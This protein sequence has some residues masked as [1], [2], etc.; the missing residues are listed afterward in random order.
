MKRVHGEI[1]WIS[2][3]LVAAL[4]SIA[5][6]AIIAADWAEGL[7]VIW[8]VALGGL[9]A[10][11]VLALS[12]FPPWLAHGFSTVYGLGWGAYWLSQ[13]VTTGETFRERLI[14]IDHRLGVWLWQVTHNEVGRDSLIFVLLLCGLAWWLAYL[15]V[16]YSQRFNRIW[17]VVLPSGLVMFINVYYA[18][19]TLNVYLG[20]YLLAA[21]LLV[22]RSYILSQEQDWRQNLV[23]YTTDIRFDLLRAG[24]TLALV[25]ILAG[26]VVPAAASSDTVAQAWHRIEGP[27]R[28]VEDTWS[29]IFA[30]LRSRG[31]VYAD[32]FGRF[33][34]LQG[35]RFLT[36]SPVMDV[37]SS[38][39]AYWR[40][41]AFNRYTGSGWMATST[42]ALSL[43]AYDRVYR[44]DAYVSREQAPDIASAPGQTVQYAVYLRHPV[45][46]TVVIFRPATS[47]VFAAPEP[48]RFS[49]PVRTEAWS[50]SDIALDPARI[51]AQRSFKPGTGYTVVSL[52]SH[53]D[54]DTLRRAGQDYPPLIREQFLGLP[55]TLPQSV[56]ELAQEITAAYDNPY[57]KATALEQWLRTNITYDDKVN[58]PP[59]NRDVVEYLLFESRRGYCDYYA[60]SMAV[61]ARAVGIPARAAVGYAVGTQDSAGGVY[62]VLEKDSHTWTEVYFPKYGW[63]DFEPTSTRPLFVRPTPAPMVTATNTLTGTP[64]PVGTPAP[65]P[66]RP[67][68]DD[69]DRPLGTGGGGL[70][71]GA[72]R[73]PAWLVGGVFVLGGLLLAAAVFLTRAGLDS[74]SLHP[75]DILLLAVSSPTAQAQH[76]LYGLSPAQRA[77][78]RLMRLANWVKVTLHAHHTPYERGELFSATVPE[79]RPA[80]SV[81]VDN[82]VREQYSRAPVAGEASQRAWELVRMDLWQAGWRQRV[83]RLQAFFRRCLETLEDLSS[84]LG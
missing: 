51:S 42:R 78:G 53:A 84:R 61:M 25:A 39:P 7:A 68:K 5:L 40:A 46:Q 18:S 80:I 29:R 57:D 77:Y 6:W 9:A 82:Y 73:F 75:T 34:T 20:A 43:E 54:E 67:E 55:N 72:G 1:D 50:P 24:F 15:A 47:L 10:G 14:E 28:T 21:L 74:W 66:E 35:A 2:F 33:L 52:V 45:T 4:V 65:R 27:W 11:L 69:D 17:R 30:S 23:G 59:P 48:L 26:W 60:S 16:W 41:A 64:A 79:G 76:S 12:R 63:I 36:D 58:P 62:H 81:I 3:G 44:S 19:G 38:E 37:R 22:A 56:R 83:D 32:P 49:L 8:T 13:Q 31:P 70:R 71:P